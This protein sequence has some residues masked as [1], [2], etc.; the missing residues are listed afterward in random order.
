M[1]NFQTKR[2]L[3]W[4]DRGDYMVVKMNNIKDE[5]VDMAEEGDGGLSGDSD[6][7]DNGCPSSSDEVY[8][9]GS[10]LITAAMSD[11]VTAQLAAA[12]ELSD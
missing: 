2:R 8:E 12:G 6:N 7:E 4:T 3:V 1:L 9:D 5:S 11:E 10:D